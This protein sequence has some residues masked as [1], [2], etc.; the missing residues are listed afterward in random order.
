MGNISIILFDSDEVYIRR[1]AA[2]LKDYLNE[3][4]SVFVFSKENQLLSSKNTWKGAV[5]FCGIKTKFNLHDFFPDSVICWLQGE[6]NVD[7]EDE[8]DRI[9][10]KYQSV[11]KI[12]GEIYKMAGIG[13]GYRRK[14]LNTQKWYGVIS[15]C[16]HGNAGAFAAAAAQI[17]SEHSRVLLVIAAE[18]SGMREL[19]ELPEMSALEQLILDLRAEDPMSEITESCFH[20]RIGNFSVLC[21]PDNPIMLC[22]L[23][24]EDVTRFET[25]LR[26]DLE[27]D[28]VIW[29]MD[30]LFGY[31]LHI[32]N[33]CNK[34][35]C[36]EKND[37]CSRCIQR[38]FETY[39]SRACTDHADSLS[40]LLEKIVLPETVW[41]EKGEHLLQQWKNSSFGEE[42]RQRIGDIDER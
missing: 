17:I 1:L 39:L 2:A 24:S 5:I 41:Q 34:I 38:E 42:I 3:G 25:Y 16:H 40:D 36:L 20:V 15:P 11:R 19:L 23:T 18:F 29:Y 13:G 31:G 7:D 21:F 6:E 4:V 14:P 28:V 32:L 27:A 10:F 37:I 22:E 8:W 12:A 9:I 33:R 26:E 35:F 30:H